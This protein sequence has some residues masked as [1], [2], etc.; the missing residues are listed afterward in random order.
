MN[1]MERCVRPL[2]CPICHDGLTRKGNRL[3]CPQ[4]HSFD[5]ARE[6]YVNLLPTNRRLPPTVGDSAEMLQARRRFLDGGHYA[7]LAARLPQ[8]MQEWATTLNR[9][10]PL[11]LLDCGCG[12]GYY[13]EWVRGALAGSG[14]CSFGM[15]VAKTAVKMAARRYPH[16]QFVAADVN[17]RL[18]FAD[19]SIDLLLDIFAPRHAA[20]FGRVVSGALLAVIPRQAHLHSLRQALGLLNIEVDKAEK[21][22]EGLRSYFQLA[23]TETLTFPL[24]LTPSQLVDLIGM[25]P[26]GR[27]LSRTQIE[28]MAGS[29]PETEAS[30]Q[31][32]VLRHMKRDA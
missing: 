30:F 12:E 18:P 17:G 32:L 6:G 23:H 19:Q 5:L 22:V 20:E 21:V 27:H 7:P 13:G 25:T 26:N 15:D 8:V 1:D 3:A 28:A 2:T 11:T 4:G 9:A 24:A 14:V 29:A 16:T 10:A 31:I